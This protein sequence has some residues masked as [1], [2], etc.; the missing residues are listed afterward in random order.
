V[1]SEPGRPLHEVRISIVQHV[2]VRI[3]H[4]SAR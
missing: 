2:T 1:L 3:C 4:A